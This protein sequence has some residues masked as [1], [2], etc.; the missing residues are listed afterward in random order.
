LLNFGIP[1]VRQAGLILSILEAADSKIQNSAK[2][3][4]EG[5][6]Y[7]GYIDIPYFNLEFYKDYDLVEDLSI[8]KY[9]DVTIS[10]IEEIKA[11]FD[12]QL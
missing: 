6:W 5:H 12:Q 7:K 8:T 1:K 4:Y 3:N 9:I 11:K 2:V 10:R